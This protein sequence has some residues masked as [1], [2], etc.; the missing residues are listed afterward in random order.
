MCHTK[1]TNIQAQTFRFV[2]LLFFAAFLF[3]PVW[4]QQE[5]PAVPLP[6]QQ[7]DM[8]SLNIPELIRTSDQKGA[9]MHQRLLEFTYI[10][11]RIEREAGPKDKV[12][13]RIREFEAYPIKTEGRHRHILSLIKKDGVALSEKQIEMNRQLAA[14]EIEQASKE[15]IALTSPGAS[16]VDQYITAGIG[17]GPGPN[18]GGVWLGVSQFLRQ[19]QFDDPRLVQFAERETIML[20]LHSC[21]GDLL[22]TRERF[23]SK[24]IG[25]VWIDV[26]DKVVVRL[27]AWPIMS[28]SAAKHPMESFTERPA[29]EVIVYEQQ[30]IQSGIWAPRRIRL[31]GLGKAAIFNGV[32]KDMVFEFSEYRHFSTEIKETEIVEPKK[33]PIPF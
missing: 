19:C 31:N 15:E 21:N 22:G 10:Q 20:R 1:F 17:I 27:E 12:Y 7:P 14:A 26:A 2:L 4:A 13:E 24:L 16:T 32:S 3:V 33:K 23:L 28:V 6:V 5:R 11:K 30:R 8:K 25:L 9:A 29:N 18:G